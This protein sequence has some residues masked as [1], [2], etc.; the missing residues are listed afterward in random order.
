MFFLFV[1]AFTFSVNGLTLGYCIIEPTQK[2]VR[3][4]PFGRH[5][6]CSEGEAQVGWLAPGRAS[7]S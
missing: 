6:E 1:L 2:G 5:S 4:F 3:S 7:V